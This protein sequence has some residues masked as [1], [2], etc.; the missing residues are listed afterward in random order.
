MRLA[1]RPVSYGAFL[2][3]QAIGFVPEKQSNI[4]SI[5]LSKLALVGLLFATG[6]LE[7]PSYVR[8]ICGFLPKDRVNYEYSFKIATLITTVMTLCSQRKEDL[9]TLAADRQNAN[10]N[11]QAFI[12][13]EHLGLYLS[14]LPFMQGAP[15]NIPSVPKQ[16][17]EDCEFLRSAVPTR[18]GAEIIKKA[19]ENFI[20]K[21]NRTYSDLGIHI[22]AAVDAAPYYDLKK[23]ARGLGE[24]DWGIEFTRD[25]TFSN[26]VSSITYAVIF[27]SQGNDCGFQRFSCAIGDLKR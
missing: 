11:I 7:T 6:C 21:F 27:S 19:I 18:E 8:K 2:Y 15:W 9:R 1:S 13:R 23:D 25:I 14:R 20:N 3:D 4:L 26:Q 10:E 22:F 17:A 5:A 24:I 16:S 12:N